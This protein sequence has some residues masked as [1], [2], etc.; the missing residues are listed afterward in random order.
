VV[1]VIALALALRWATTL[2]LPSGSIALLFI[3][4]YGVIRAV[5]AMARPDLGAWPLWVDQALSLTIAAAAGV[6]LWLRASAM[7][8]AQPAK[9]PSGTPSTP[10]DAAT[11]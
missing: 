1:F 4:G 11:S 5:V 10:D 9:D 2:R 7:P 8:A 3:G 6:L